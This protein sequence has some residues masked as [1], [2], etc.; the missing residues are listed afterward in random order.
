MFLDAADHLAV[1]E[2]RG[3]C[4][5]HFQLDAPCLAHDLHIEVAISIEDL[6]RVVG[7]GAAVENGKRT[8]AEQRVEASLT[9]VQQLA[10]LRLREVFEAAARADASVDEIRN[11]IRYCPREPLMEGFR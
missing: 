2:C 5:V 1:D 8:L 3:G 11:E 6:F 10:D 4:V 7:V 9:G